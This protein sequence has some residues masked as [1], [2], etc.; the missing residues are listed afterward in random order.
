MLFI[1]SDQ[2]RA[3]CLEPDGDPVRTP[4]LDALAAQ[5]AVLTNAVSNYPVCSPHRAML[6]TGQPP[7][8][9]HVPLNVNSGTAPEVGLRPGA[10]SWAQVLRDGGYRTGYIG[11]WH[12][13]APT[14]A[15]AIH[16][17][18]PLEDGRYWD[19]Y[20]PPSHR[21]G[22]EFWHSYGCNDQHLTPHY[23]VG[24]APRERRTNINRW[25]AAHETDVA[26]E[27]LAGARAG[28]APF[29]LAVS[30]NPPHQPFDELPPGY[31]T[32]YAA[33]PAGQLLNR[34]NVDLASSIGREAAAIAPL[35]YAAV[36]AIDEQVGRLLDALAELDLARDTIVVFTSDHGQ[37]MG[38][39]N[40]L[41]KNVPYEE[42]M[43]LPCLIRWPGHIAPGQQPALFCSLDIAPT[44]LGLTG[45]ADS[46]PVQM[47]GTNLA[48][49][50]L[51]AAEPDTEAAATYYCYPLHPTDQ[52][53]RGLRTSTNK[54]IARLSAGDGLVTECY[55]LRKD[56][57][58]LVP[59]L[60]P[61]VNSLW[62]ARLVA[63]LQTAGD[64]WMGLSALKE[65]ANA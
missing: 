27:F 36:T 15:D 46:K 37:Q 8:E 33:L 20:S 65:L 19:A 35:Y 60:D 22:F 28:A 18:G 7:H 24:N 61:D 6:V 1:I 16:G 50:L 56:P 29:A 57:Y 4:A 13:A 59:V 25:S 17:R 45:F 30:F 9:N 41:Y 55:D 14:A 51:G 38:S 2:F 12:L 31:A 53:I 5:S 48:P 42:S 21:F 26:L 34:P 39:H 63:E 11:K 54:F 47:R 44:L 10:P 43:R 32:D 52:D 64:D 49:V 58:E 40:L 62:A 3:M 23:W